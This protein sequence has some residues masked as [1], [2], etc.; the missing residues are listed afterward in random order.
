MSRDEGPQDKDTGRSGAYGP[1]RTCD[2]GP[3]IREQVQDEPYV[4]VTWDVGYQSRRWDSCIRFRSSP[5]YTDW[6]SRGMVLGVLWSKVEH[7]ADDEI[8][9]AWLKAT[10]LDVRD[11]I[12][13]CGPEV[14]GDDK[15]RE[16]FRV[17]LCKQNGSS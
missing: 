9:E 3:R 1:D 11:I 2:G 6:L 15:T 7:Q 10:G 14:S 13:P 4:K 17:P 5:G 16:A 8:C 12:S